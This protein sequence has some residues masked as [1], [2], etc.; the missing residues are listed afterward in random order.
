[1]PKIFSLKKISALHNQIPSQKLV[2]ATGVFDILHVEHLRFLKKAKAQGDLLIVGVES[3]KRVRE[4]KGKDR[5]VNSQKKRAQK[6]AKQ[7]VVDC[8]FVLPDNLATKKGR[9]EFIKTLRPDIYA[10]STSTPF[11][12]EKQRILKKFG[13]KLKVVH[14]HNPKIS[15]TK[16]ITAK[17]R[18][19][20][21]IKSSNI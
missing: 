1:M 5:P 21:R 8:V 7:D 20:R 16:I 11:Q 9:E 2:L 13:G 10:V 3:D 12:A 15:T 6:I 17:P 19:R 4:L 14:P 18:N